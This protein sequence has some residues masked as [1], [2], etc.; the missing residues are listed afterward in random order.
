MTA[1]TTALPSLP[2]L[3]NVFNLRET[4]YFQNTLGSSAQG[5]PLSLFVG[6]EQE[7]QTLLAGI[8][9]TRS[10]R[11]AICGAAGVGKTTL[12][13]QIKAA[14]IAA[15]Y[16][17]TDELVPVYEDDDIERL[18][19][20]MLSVLYDTILA[21]RPH[22][23]DHA[24]MRDAQQLVKVARLTAGGA[25]VSVLGIGVGG[26]RSTNLVTPP[27]AMLLDG[28][29]IMRAMLALVQEAESQGVVMH[30]NNLENLSDKGATRAADLLRSLRDTVLLLE[31]LHILLVGTVDAVFRA[32][33]THA[34][35]RSIFPVPLVLHAMPID[36]VQ[37]LLAARYAYL[38][39]DDRTPVPPA[40]PEAVGQ[41][42]P[43]FRGDLRSL[44]SALDE[45]TRLLIGTVPAGTSIPFDL[46]HP[47]LRERY[48]AV[49]NERLS[50][51][52]RR[53]LEAW[54]AV[55]AETAQ[56]QLELQGLW[57]LTQ[58]KVSKTLAE[59]E[60]QG[61]VIGLPRDGRSPKQYVLSG[62]SRLIFAA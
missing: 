38:A 40:A 5:Y 20:R 4:P 60:T 39:I 15:G 42:Y 2:N 6:R 53:Y 61:Y 33:N 11:A 47:A 45:G 58:S 28:P 56:T 3:W 46:L 43:L 16:F 36:D 32:V 12:V 35:V 24:V 26:S 8:G 48:E 10:S 17:A 1:P 9:G 55:G 31:G 25:N 34:Q 21:A 14:A 51:I 41:L 44:L 22:T 49:L 19:G 29:R 27:G 37:R 13:Q 23:A 57:A 18:L 54:A 30:L 59:L 62:V 52:R 7:T 50:E